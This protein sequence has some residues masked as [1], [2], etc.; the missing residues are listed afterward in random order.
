MV[1]Y[2]LTGFEALINHFL[3]LSTHRQAAKCENCTKNDEFLFHIILFL[4]F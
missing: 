1:A 2:L 4:F 3:H